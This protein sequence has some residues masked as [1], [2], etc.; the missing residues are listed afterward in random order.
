MD[1][2]AAE[3]CP[4]GQKKQDRQDEPAEYFHKI[5]LNNVTFPDSSTT[6]LSW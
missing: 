3:G 6:P 4:A 2:L 5:Y 1:I